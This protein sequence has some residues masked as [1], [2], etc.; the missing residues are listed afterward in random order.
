MIS[1]FFIIPRITWALSATF[2]LI[3]GIYFQKAPNIWFL[4]LIGTFCCISLLILSFVYKTYKN[5]LKFAVLLAGFFVAGMGRMHHATMQYSAH[6][7][8]LLTHQQPLF[9]QL[10]DYEITAHQQYPYAYTFSL[11]NFHNNI[12]NFFI[13]G[14]SLKIY[15]SQKID[16]HVGD[17]LEI[18]YL[19]LAPIPP[20][21]YQKYLMKE[22]IL[23]TSFV[24]KLYYRVLESA[25]SIHHEIIT[26]RNNTIQDLK[27]K[28]SESTFALFAPLFLGNKYL[29]DR[30][31]FRSIKQDFKYWGITHYLARSGLHVVLFIALY[32]ILCM[33]LPLPFFGKHILMLILLWFYMLFSWSSVSFLRA[34][35]AYHITKLCLFNYVP[36]LTLHIICLTCL[37]TLLLNP[38]QLFFLD[39]QLSFFLTFCLA[40]FISNS[41]KTIV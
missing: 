41:Q 37:L 22:G 9:V 5:Y 34:F 4:S 36:S 12:Y 19:S 21:D 18:K 7:Q 26:M 30:E 16:A 15:M 23:I 32:N 27:S 39:F 13:P 14:Y 2:A 10:E 1:R 29:V 6:Q 8:H 3:A 11:Y 38:F 40:W 20:N 17:I 35:I 28:M 25:P 33:L 24:K 31:Q